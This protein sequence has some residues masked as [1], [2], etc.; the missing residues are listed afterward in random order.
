MRVRGKV[1]DDCHWAQAMEK[2][3][4]KLISRSDPNGLETVLPRKFDGF[5]FSN[6]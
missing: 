3:G 4:V 6:N 1:D 2:S 5:N